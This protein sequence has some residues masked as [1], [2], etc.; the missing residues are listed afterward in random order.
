MVYAL[1]HMQQSMAMIPLETE[2]KTQP[3]NSACKAAWTLAEPTSAEFPLTRLAGQVTKMTR[4]ALATHLPFLHPPVLQC[5]L[6][7]DHWP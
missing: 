2:P 5:H 4:D 7:M 1:S 6:D 3:L